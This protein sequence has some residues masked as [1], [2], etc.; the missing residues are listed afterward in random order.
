MRGSKEKTDS[1]SKMSSARGE[2]IR[3]W[4]KRFILLTSL[5]FFSSKSSDVHYRCMA[6]LRMIN[7]S[8]VHTVVL[9]I[10]YYLFVL[11]RRPEDLIKHLAIMEL[12]AVLYD[13]R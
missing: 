8:K 4:K 13:D 9:Y 10:H 2:S 6:L 11:Q 5:L 12:R 7:N 1:L 3:H